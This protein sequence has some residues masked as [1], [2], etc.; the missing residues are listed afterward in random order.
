MKLKSFLS[1]WNDLTQVL[2]SR[3]LREW[4]E[5]SHLDS[6][7]PTIILISGF[8][9]SN[10]NLSVIRKRFLRDGFNVVILS[11]SWEALADSVR[12]LYRM[13]EILS[14][15]VLQLKKVPGMRR[16]KVYLVAHSAGGLVARYYV[17]LLG[18]DHYCD[19][20]ITLATPHSGTWM[21]ALGFLS[22]LLLKAR[23]LFQMLPISPFIRNVN[24]AFFPHGFKMV[25]LYSTEDFMC[26][27]QSTQLP[28][29]FLGEKRI[30]SIELHHLSHSDFLLS[31]KCYAEI[32]KF[33]DAELET[34]EDRK[35]I[36]Q[37]A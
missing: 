11:L 24:E 10:R 1:L 8:G 26:P 16:S 25:S 4:S 2:P 32:K 36:P 6:K 5:L 31:R 15:T 27:P 23:C 13:A 17:Q 12:G 19:G 34:P 22:P 29:G 14:S 7:K 9:A 3:S 33:L 21:A 18:G 20:L 28:E 30:Q 35:Q 37:R